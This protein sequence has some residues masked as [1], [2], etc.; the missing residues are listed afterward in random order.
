VLGM[1]VT[2]YLPRVAAHRKWKLSQA[3]KLAGQSSLSHLTS[4]IELQD[5]KFA[6]CDSYCWL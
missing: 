6:L 3:A 5:L 1:T 4:Y 2:G